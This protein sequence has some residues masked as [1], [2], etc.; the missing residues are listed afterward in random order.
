MAL[1]QS[2]SQPAP[3]EEVQLTERG[4]ISDG[5]R[6][7]S[8]VIHRLPPSSFPDLPASIADLLNRRDCL[9]PQTYEA[10]RPENLLHASLEHAGSSDWA[11]L[12]SAKG[13]VSLL[14]FFASAPDRPAVLATAPETERLQSH[15]PSGVLGFNWGI[16]PATPERVREAETGLVRRPPPTDHDA[17]ADSIVEHRTVFHFYSRGQWTLLDI[18]EP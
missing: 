18:P 8:F 13:M 15:D 5:S 2:P 3:P 14:V 10:H 11:M 1:A 9:I 6:S 12:C 4:H 7:V 16:D 17:I